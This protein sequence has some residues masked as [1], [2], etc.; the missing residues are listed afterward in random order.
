V[1]TEA[2]AE[3]V[4]GAGADHVIIYTRQHFA[5]EVKKATDGKGVQVVYD[6]VGKTT[7][8]KS[9][10]CLGRRGYMVLYG[11]ASGPVPPMDPRVLAN[12]SLF[13]TRPGLGDYTATRE[14]LEQ[15]AGDV[16]GWV[17]SGELKLRVEHVFPLSEAAE[18]HRQLESRATTGKVV[19]IP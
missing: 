9:I 11:Q 8:D 10:S 4:K 5:E 18:A 15:R 7:F 17:K 12:G 14:E 1:S 2:K 6:A 3:L 19:L 16:L 13:L